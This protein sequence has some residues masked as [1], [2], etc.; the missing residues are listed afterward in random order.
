VSSPLLSSILGSLNSG[1][2]SDVASRAGV[3]ES[4]LTKGIEPLAATLLNGA[5]TKASNPGVASQLFSLVSG[6]SSDDAGKKLI[7]TESQDQI[8]NIAAIMKADLNVK[9][10]IAGYTDNTGDVAHNQKLSQ[11]RAEGVVKSLVAL[12]ISADRLEAQGYGEEHAIGR[13]RLKNAAR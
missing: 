7:S 9:L 11:D 2:I 3:S 5:A 13:T 6:P 12:G 10:K 4:A 1:S 8:S